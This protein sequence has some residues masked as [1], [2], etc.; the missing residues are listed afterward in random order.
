M[1]VA[2]GSSL[3]IEKV[4]PRARRRTHA[5]YLAVVGFALL[6]LAMV[7]VHGGAAVNFAFPLLAT[8]LGG[9]LFVYRRSTY[10][11]Y[12][13]WVWLFTPEVCRL[14]D[15]KTDSHT[16]G[17]VMLTPMLVTAFAAFKR[18]GDFFG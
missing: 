2:I 14:V 13:G 5:S 8:S 11:A 9:A 17:R 15:Y 3:L 12:T 7:A 4:E 10:V 16:I 18:I 1:S 6:T